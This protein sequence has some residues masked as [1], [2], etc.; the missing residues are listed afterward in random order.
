ML[1]GTLYSIVCVVTGPLALPDLR[2]RDPTAGKGG[3]D[4]EERAGG[5]VRRGRGSAWA[6]HGRKRDEGVGV[7]VRSGGD[8][9][10]LHLIC[11]FKKWLW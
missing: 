8:S 1:I 6:A 4:S 10:P 2:A 7:T 9:A 5:M 3:K 11:S